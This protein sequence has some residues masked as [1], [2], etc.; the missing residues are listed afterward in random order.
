MKCTAHLRCCTRWT[1]IA[2]KNFVIVVVVIVIVRVITEVHAVFDVI[3]VV[4]PRDVSPI[5]EIPHKIFQREIQIGE[6]D[7]FGTTDIFLYALF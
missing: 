6:I 2:A 7:V 5:G 3:V 1:T 4:P